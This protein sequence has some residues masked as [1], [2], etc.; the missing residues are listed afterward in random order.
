MAAK[1]RFPLIKVDSSKCLTPFDCK[2]CLR[3]CPQAIF[4]VYAIKV[5]K[6]KET[7]KKEPGAYKLVPFYRDKCTMCNKCIDVCPVNAITITLPEE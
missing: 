5:E 7:D 2:K 1:V 3:I 6:F 4:E